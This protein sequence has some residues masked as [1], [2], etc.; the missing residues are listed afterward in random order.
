MRLAFLILH[1]AFCILLLAASAWGQCPPGQTCPVSPLP[2]QG[3]RAWSPPPRQ[4]VAANPAVVRVWSRDATGT[5]YGSGTIFDRRGKYAY[6]VTAAHV[7]GR[8]KEHAVRIGSTWHGAVVAGADPAWDVAVLKMFDLGIKPLELADQAPVKGQHISLSGFGSGSYG[9]GHGRLTQFV[10]PGRGSLPFEWMEVSVGSREGD[11]GG[12]MVNARGRLVG[13]ISRTRPGHTVGCCFPRLRA[14]VRGVLP[15]YPNRPGVIIPK[16]MVVLPVSP[17]I[18]HL[19]PST[20]DPSPPIVCKDCK[21]LKDSLAII[22]GKLDELNGRLLTLEGPKP[23]D[24]ASQGPQRP[25]GERGETSA[26]G[27]T[28]APP[29][30]RPEPPAQVTAAVLDYDELATAILKQLDLAALRGAKGDKGD[31]GDT[32]DAG[33]TPAINLD[34]LAAKVT[35][36]LDYDELAATIL[37]QIDPE[38]FRGPAGETGPPGPPGEVSQSTSAGSMIISVEP[39]TSTSER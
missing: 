5:F 23:Y 12:P 33:D 22:N 28:P 36:V 16:P 4:Q 34:D 7:L 1:S 39:L 25:P 2:A 15:P 32:G 35:A 37:K 19:P 24:P 27:P 3:W 8:G 13:V 30:V 10:A 6:V 29:Q 9:T 14:I 18:P 38:N 31:K 20:I 21:Q 26:A 11:S 17:P